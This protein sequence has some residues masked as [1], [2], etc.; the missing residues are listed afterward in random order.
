MIT[1]IH[2]CNFFP[3]MNSTQA[4]H[5]CIIQPREKSTHMNDY[6][7][8]YPTRKF[9]IRRK[10]WNLSLFLG[11]TSQPRNPSTR[12]INSKFVNSLGQKKLHLLELFRRKNQIMPLEKYWTS[13]WTVLNNFCFSEK[14]LIPWKVF[15]TA[16]RKLPEMCS[17]V[18]QSEKAT[19]SWAQ[20]AASSYNAWFYD[21]L[22]Y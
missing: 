1:W 15:V 21:V 2:L 8:E 10:D 11:S 17:G 7:F 3:D 5:D 16:L 20:L 12:T 4:V 9:S 13:F 22:A 6:S 19:R 18:S 14:F